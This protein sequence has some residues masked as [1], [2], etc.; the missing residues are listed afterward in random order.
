LY[1]HVPMGF[2]PL[3][4]HAKHSMGTAVPPRSTHPRHPAT[5]SPVELQS[6]GAPVHD[7]QSGAVVQTPLQVTPAQ[8]AS[9]IA[10]SE[11]PPS[12]VSAIPVSCAEASGIPVS[13][14]PVSDTLASEASGP[15]APIPE[16]SS[17]QATSAP[18]ATVPSRRQAPSRLGCFMGGNHTPPP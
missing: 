3:L 11:M 5:H 2:R 7:L 15:P 18:G 8:P 6:R 16:T 10:E 1:W 14:D 12:P 9:G 13:L 17:P 4:S